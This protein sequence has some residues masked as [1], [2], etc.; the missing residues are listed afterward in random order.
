MNGLII[1]DLQAA[2]G[3]QICSFST[4]S[5]GYLN[6]KW[7]VETDAGDLLV[8]QYSHER[9]SRRKLNEIEQA[10]KR[11]MILFDAGIPCPR[12]W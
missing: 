12:I 4:V 11:Q 1:Q 9:F 2:F 5:G 3:I 8:K 6:K 7:R 10:L